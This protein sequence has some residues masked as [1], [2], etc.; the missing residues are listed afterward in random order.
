M[1]DDYELTPWERADVDFE[2]WF[3][4]WMR[5][6]E[7][8]FA[9]E[10]EYLRFLRDNGPRRDREWLDRRAILRRKMTATADLAQAYRD[11]DPLLVQKEIATMPKEESDR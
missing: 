9:A 8:R 4:G 11:G 7:R 5:V 2:S 1:S 10:E 3:A 6:R